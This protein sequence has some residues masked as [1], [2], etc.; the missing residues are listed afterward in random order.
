[1]D[2]PSAQLLA[3]VLWIAG[4]ALGLWVDAPFPTGAWL[5]GLT[6]LVFAFVGRRSVLTES[7]P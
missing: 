2:L 3:V 5:T 1:M 6:L 7:T 4:L